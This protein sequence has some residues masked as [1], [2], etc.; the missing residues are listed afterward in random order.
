[1]FSFI[2]LAAGD[3]FVD[4][5]DDPL[6]TNAMASS[7]WE[8]EILQNHVSPKVSTFVSFI[9]RPL[10][11]VE[12]DLVPLIENSYEQV[13]SRSKLKLELEITINGESFIFRYSRRNAR[14]KFRRRVWHLRN[15]RRLRFRKRITLRRFGISTIVDGFWRVISHAKTSSWEQFVI[16]IVSTRQRE[17]LPARRRRAWEF[18]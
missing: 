6:K 18:E 13:R 4:N 11:T 5:E 2:F 14:V 16:Q 10:P 12:S 1:M 17:V 7:L 15:H 9:N 8:L 3:P